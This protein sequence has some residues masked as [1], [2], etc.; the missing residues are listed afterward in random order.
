MKNKWPKT[1]EK[2][3][4]G[5]YPRFLSIMNDIGK[6]QLSPPPSLKIAPT[7]LVGSENVTIFSKVER[8]YRESALHTKSELIHLLLTW[9]FQI[10]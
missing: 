8:Q 5:G 6:C 1:D 10:H 9:A 3:I 4:F 7:P 2:N